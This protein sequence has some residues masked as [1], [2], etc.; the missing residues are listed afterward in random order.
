MIFDLIDR[1]KNLL[2]CNPLQTS[3]LS[4]YTVGTQKIEPLAWNHCNMNSLMKILLVSKFHQ[5]RLYTNLPWTL[6]LIA[7]VSTRNTKSDFAHLSNY[8]KTLNESD[9]QS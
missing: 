6:V 8:Q 5:L 7:F 9:L 1:P 3:I 2:E 4:N